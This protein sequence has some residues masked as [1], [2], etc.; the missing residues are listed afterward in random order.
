MGEKQ[1]KSVAVE[2]CVCARDAVGGSISEFHH[3]SSGCSDTTALTQD[4]YSRAVKH[5]EQ[6]DSTCHSSSSSNNNT[7][8]ANNNTTT[9]NSSGSNTISSNNMLLKQRQFRGRAH[10]HAPPTNAGPNGCFVVL[11]SASTS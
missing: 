4:A 11:N 8:T 10:T 3:Q 7:I 1:K 5:F 6:I 9:N 2:K